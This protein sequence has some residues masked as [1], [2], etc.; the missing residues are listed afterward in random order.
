MAPTNPQPGWH[1][2]IRIFSPG[3]FRIFGDFSKWSALSIL[4]LNSIFSALTCFPV[5]Y[6]ARRV[7]GP[8][9]AVWAGWAWA[10]YPFAVY[11]ASVRVWETC[12]TTLLL[13]LAVWLTLVL[14]DGARLIPWLTYG[15]LW[16]LAAL[17]SPGVLVILPALVAYIFFRTHRQGAAAY[18]GRTAMSGMVFLV[19]VTPWF[20]RNFRAFHEF[21]PF[22][23]NLGLELRMGNNGDTSDVY[24][25]SAHPAHNPAELHELVTLGETAYFLRKKA[26]ALDFIR[27]YPG[28]FLWVTARRFVFLWTGFWSLRHEFLANEPFEI[29]NIL[30]STSMTI[31]MLIGGKRAWRAVGAAS[32]PLL[33]CIIL[34]P[35]IYYL[36][37][38]D[39][40]YRH[41]VD[42]EIV[43]FI[44]YALGSICAHRKEPC[45]VQSA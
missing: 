44:V 38:V 39:L 5:L 42:P 31:L 4:G 25:D 17:T 35:A 22:R 15:A 26:Q 9:T 33:F 3:V 43:I 34:F 16:A 2:S 27:E 29:P 21:V 11:F 28:F 30:F 37:H 20:V 6:I 12:L 40:H 36:T 24:I 23:D 7:F 18:V 45:V 32:L 13:S 41:P 1:P 8:R 19:L 14:A 10:V